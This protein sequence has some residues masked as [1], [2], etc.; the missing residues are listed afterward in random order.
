MHPGGVKPAAPTADRALGY[1]EETRVNLRRTIIAAATVM[2]LALAA[3]GT[4]EVLAPP[5]AVQEAARST[6]DRSSMQLTFSLAGDADD[7]LALFGEGAAPTDDDRRGVDVVRDSRLTVSFDR[8]DE[9]TVDDD[10]FALDLDVGDIDH[11]VEVRVVAKTLYARADVP[12]LAEYFGFQTG[13]LAEAV[14]GAE[15]AG[16]GFLADAVAGRWLSTD[17]APLE[18]M[19]E[20]GAGLDAGGAE[21]LQPFLDALASAFSEDVDVE[22]VGKDGAGE[23]YRLTVALRRVYERLLPLLGSLPGLPGP[24]MIPPASEVPDETVTA[25]VWVADGR[26]SRGELDLAQFAPHATGPVA[27]RV[28]ISGL[29]GDITA[30]EGAVD[31]NVMQILGSFL[32]AVGVGG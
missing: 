1:E 11:A 18:A 26:I 14:A 30:P 21:Q 32:G 16:F 29:D 12:L 23:R 15:T 8:G 5:L 25:D 13:S 22:R 31:V 27:L 24:G 10:R 19:A 28:D 17:L 9:A 6:L 3:C 7:I 4:A 2:A 20:G